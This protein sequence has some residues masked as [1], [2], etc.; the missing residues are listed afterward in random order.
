MYSSIVCVCVLK[1]PNN[2]VTCLFQQEASENKL[3]HLSCQI[4]I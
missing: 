3:M 2:R 4:A 1:P